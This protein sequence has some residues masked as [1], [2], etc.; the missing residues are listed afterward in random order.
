[1]LIQLKKEGMIKMENLSDK[2]IKRIDE[3]AKDNLQKEVKELLDSLK[4]KAN[5]YVVSKLDTNGLGQ[6]VSSD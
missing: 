2:E 6:L 4:E 5:D 1:M 3:I